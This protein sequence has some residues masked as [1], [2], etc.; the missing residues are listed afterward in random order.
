MSLFG[1]DHF[2][3]TRSESKFLSPLL[4]FFFGEKNV[5][6]FFAQGLNKTFSSYLLHF[7]KFQLKNT[8]LTPPPSIS[9]FCQVLT[10]F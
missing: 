5:L 8:N 2:Q 4:F 6:E 1:F 10:S 9:L 3:S 7:S